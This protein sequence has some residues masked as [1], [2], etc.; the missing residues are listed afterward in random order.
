MIPLLSQNTE[1][2]LPKGKRR[3]ENK[4]HK[5]LAAA[6]EGAKQSGNPFLPVIEE[7]TELRQGLRLA[8]SA[9][10]KLLACLLPESVPVKSAIDGYCQSQG[11]PPTSVACL[12]GPEGDFTREEVDAA[13]AAGFVPVTLG[14]YVLRCETAAVAALRTVKLGGEVSPALGYQVIRPPAKV[15]PAPTEQKMMLS[16]SSKI[17]SSAA[18]PR[19]METDAA[20]VLPYF[21]TVTM[22]FS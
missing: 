13:L 22:N 5:W 3:Q 8:D 19:A 16:P 17:P 6:I 1:F 7:P 20:D 10:L 4:G 11:A 14:P 12:V 2:K 15:K 21:P 9:D 18:Q